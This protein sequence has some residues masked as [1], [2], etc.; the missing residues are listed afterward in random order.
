MRKATVLL[1]VTLCSLLMQAQSGNSENPTVKVAVAPNYPPLAV[2]ARISGTV[3]VRTVVDVSGSVL[4]AEVTA[5]HP[6]LRRAATDAAKKWMFDTSS[7]EKRTAI[8]SFGFV[9][10]PEKAGLESQTSFLPPYS[11]EVKKRPA[12]PTVNY[13][14]RSGKPGTLPNYDLSDFSPNI[15][16]LHI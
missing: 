6:M 15:S 2:A 9:L 7:Q 5:G 13:G 16:N 3:T 11:V 8:L 12:K 4:Q 1:V 10:L 14:S